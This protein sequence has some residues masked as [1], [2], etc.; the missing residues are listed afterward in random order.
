LLTERAETGAALSRHDRELRELTAVVKRLGT[1]VTWIERHIRSSGAART[2]DLDDVEP[3]LVGLAEI[4]EAGHRAQDSLL[5]PF[6]RAGLEATVADHRD[7]DAVHRRTVESLLQA[8]ARLVGTDRDDPPHRRQTRADYLA[9]RDALADAARRREA[10]ADQARSAIERL[11]ADDD[12]RRARAATIE[13]GRRAELELLTR[14]RTRLAAAV[15]DGALL[16]AWL[17]QSIGPM[18]GAG[19]AQR[20]TEVAAGLLAYRIT[21][22]LDDP[23]EALGEL[24]DTATGYRRRWHAELGRGVRE[25]RR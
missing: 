16:P 5:T 8:C 14:L 1:Q 17:T 7:A 19:T 4:A 11:T 15:G 9:A 20:W 18:P 25:L 2:L 3:E 13:A 23:E 6:A 10:I 24:P 22:R 21:Y 12:E